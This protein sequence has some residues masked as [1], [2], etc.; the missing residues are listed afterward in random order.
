MWCWGLE[1]MA[2]NMLSKHCTNRAAALGQELV[3]C[4][5]HREPAS[6][7]SP[8]LSHTIWQWIVKFKKKFRSQRGAQWIKELAVKADNLRWSPGIH[9]A[10][11]LSLGDNPWI[12]LWPSHALCVTWTLSHS[13]TYVIHFFKKFSKYYLLI[14]W[15][16]TSVTLISR[17]C[18]AWVML[19]L[20]PSYSLMLSWLREF[21]VTILMPWLTPM[22]H[23]H[24][25]I[26]AV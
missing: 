8:W 12:V 6:E 22:E 7:Q 9:M 5:T 21:G 10:E 3:F 19:W 17:K 15:I 16:C 25:L 14:Y 4:H 23:Q 26:S 20:R 18:R 24:C 1:P 11:G 13:P 2:L